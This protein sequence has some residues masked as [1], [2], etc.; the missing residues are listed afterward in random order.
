LPGGVLAAIVVIVALWWP[1]PARGVDPLMG[2]G[3]ALLVRDGGAG[4]GQAERRGADRTLGAPGG[5]SGDARPLIGARS[6]AGE[7]GGVSS[8]AWM[9]RTAGA[10]VLVVGLI[11]GVKWLMR[12]ASGSLGGLRGQLGAGG[13]APSGVLFVLGRYPV[14]KGQTLVLIRMDRRVLLLGQS[15][16]GFRTLSEV[17]GA[18]EV[19]SISGKCS[20]AMGEGASAAFRRELGR[21]SRDPAIVGETKAS[22]L[23]LGGSQLS[24]L[25]DRLSGGAAGRERA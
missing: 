13:R 15:A 23:P 20:D 10:L 1:A 2:D 9:V 6:G 11:F 8:G 22:A 21:A 18:E 4:F 7:G 14:S 16:D 17:T 5:T 19:A 24:G 12:K 3:G 25:I